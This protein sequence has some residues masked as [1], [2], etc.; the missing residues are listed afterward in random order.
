LTQGPICAK[1]LGMIC[2]LSSS[3]F[4]VALGLSLAACGGEAA[5]KPAE[6]PKGAEAKPASNAKIVAPGNAKIGDTSKC[7]VSGEE[8]V[9][10][11]SS[12]KAEFEGKTYYFCCSGC[13]KKFESDPKKFLSENKG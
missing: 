12:P 6:A 2:K 11:A 5:Q 7:P 3:F 10:E 9:V 13:K 4:A 8:F 1:P